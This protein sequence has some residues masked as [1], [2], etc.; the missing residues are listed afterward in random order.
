MKHYSFIISDYEHSGDL[1]WARQHA[2]L[3]FPDIKNIKTYEERDY[4]AE[5]DYEDDYGECDE[6]IYQGYIEFDTPDEYVK[7]LDSFSF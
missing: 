1:D 6:P 7:E 2:L 5:S 4:E 3:N